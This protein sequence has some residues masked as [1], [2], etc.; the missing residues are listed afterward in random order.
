MSH[1]CVCVSIGDNWIITIKSY[2]SAGLIW[3]I[4]PVVMIIINDIMAYIFGFFFGKTPL[5]QLSPKK[6]WEGFIGG[7][8]MTVLFGLALSYALCQYPYFVCPIEYSEE[9]DRIVITDC[10]PSYLYIPQEYKINIVSMDESRE[11]FSFPSL[12]SEDKSLTF[13]RVFSVSPVGKFWVNFQY[14]AICTSFTVA[15]HL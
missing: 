12:S 2:L 1:T 9:A 15:E 4:I 8:I 7:G 10:T 13:F 14:S 3:F 5:I 6:T 11:S